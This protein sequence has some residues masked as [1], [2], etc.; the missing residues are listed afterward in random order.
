[1]TE[2]APHWQDTL[3]LESWTDVDLDLELDAPSSKLA[4]AGCD[5]PPVFHLRLHVQR[6]GMPGAYEYK[7]SGDV[8]GD[9]G[10]SCVRCL[11]P[12]TLG[13]RATF[14]LRFLP[15]SALPLDQMGRDEREMLDEDVDIE[16]YRRPVFDL[17]SLVREQVYLELPMDPVC[18]ETCEGLC[19]Y[20]GVNRSQG[21]HQ[22][23]R[24]IHD[25][26]WDALRD[27]LPKN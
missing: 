24:K 27:L 26:R 4:L 14:D 12:F 11:E 18:R 7:L 23:D 22:C 9:V 21:P 20:C 10:V 17:L 25:P 1:M 6:A 13:L 16:Y 2:K 3:D 15:I 8:A 19:P 5:C